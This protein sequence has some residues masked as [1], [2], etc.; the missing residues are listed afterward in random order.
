M[1]LEGC[2]FL[3]RKVFHL[4]EIDKKKNWN[5]PEPTDVVVFSM[6]WVSFTWFIMPAT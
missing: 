1:L 2:R 4:A 5:A 6:S 3:F